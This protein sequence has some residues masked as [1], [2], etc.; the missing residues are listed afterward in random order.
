MGEI[1]LFS[2]QAGIAFFE[3]WLCYQFLFI[4]ILENERLDKKEKIIEWG[5]IV[6]VGLL[7]SVNRMLLFFSRT[8][9]IFCIVITSICV[10]YIK[11]KD[12]V[13]SLGTVALLFSLISLIDF[14]FAFLSMMFLQQQFEHKVYLTMTYW[15]IIIFIISRLIIYFCLSA[16]RKKI[17]EIDFREYKNILILWSIIFYGVLRYYQN[18]LSDMVDGVLKMKGGSAGFSLFVLVIIVLF[19]GI[20]L[21]K[22]QSIKKENE[23]LI[24]RDA[25]V[26][27]KYQE[28]AKL[29]EKN[30]EL[31]H[32]INNHL[33]I[34][35]G[36]AE[37]ND[38]KRIKAY[39]EKIGQNV[40]DSNIGGTWTGNKTLDML[41][42]Q[43][44]SV[45]EQMGIRFEIE[46]VY[47]PYLPF[48]DNQICSLFGNLLDN[49]LEACER[50]E[51]SNRWILIRI[52]KQNQMLFI[53]IINSI[54][55]KPERKYG[56]WISSKLDKKIH[57]YGQKSVG[58]IVEE[59]G[60]VISYQVKDNVFS[61][62]LSFFD[63]NNATYKK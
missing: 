16:I 15:Q 39:L 32:D 13:L 36:F 8:V 49:A 56:E 21:L 54:E 27:Q 28:M 60:G 58:R 35:N 55:K 48:N 45:S 33:L 61:V 9:F 7:L 43:K 14:L 63:V 53:E 47:H 2:I 42:S 34:L 40:F 59:Y 23:F 20:I 3:V 22:N 41:L 10:I 24:S 30:R 31:V 38:C 12:I 50:M 51:G 6:V 52:E 5:N 29:I 25:I 19:I 57:G 62:D 46:S 37:A 18:I 1:L 11:G 4:T 44:K 17:A 26:E